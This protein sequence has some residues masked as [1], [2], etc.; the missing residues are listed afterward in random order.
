LAKGQASDNLFVKNSDAWTQEI[1]VDRVL[2]RIGFSSLI[3]AITLS[4][5]WNSTSAAGEQRKPSKQDS[6]MEKCFAEAR[7]ALGLDAEVL[8]CGRLTDGAHLETVA[9]LRLRR[10]SANGEIPVSKLVVLRQ[11]A[12]EWQ[13]ELSVDK[14]IT[15]EKGY[16]GIEFI[17][18]SAEHAGYR[19]KLSDHRSDGTPGFT[20]QLR[21]LH[22]NGGSEW[23]IEIS[24]N[25]LV[26]RFEEYADEDPP[27]FKPEV[28]NPPHK[29]TRN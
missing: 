2:M 14:W 19:V 26:K 20:V 13:V 15:N 10:F 5:C 25:P 18:D 6:S 28:K 23:P 17:D 4:G 12:P 8:K 9:A 1:C 11:N 22:G 7:K 24:W 16:L 27:R 21:F 3:L 29:N